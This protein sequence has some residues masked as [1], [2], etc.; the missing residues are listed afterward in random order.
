MPPEQPMPSS[1]S[2]SS[3]QARAERIYETEDIILKAKMLEVEFLDKIAYL[4]DNESLSRRAKMALTSLI[5]MAFD[6]NVVLANNPDIEL[7]MLRFDEALNKTKLSYSRPDAMNPAIV[8]LHENIRQAFRDFV[9]RSY[10]M[11]ERR[12]Q[13][14]RKSVTESVMT[15]QE[16]QDRTGQPP[17]QRKHGFGKLGELFGGGGS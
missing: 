12:M 2:P 8:Y 11:N 4:I 15:P 13:G 17:Q 3:S 10:M 6:K 1:G 5:C 7:R 16:I 9:S 14:E